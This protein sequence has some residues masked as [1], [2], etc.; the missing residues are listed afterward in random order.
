[1]TY[2]LNPGRLESWTLATGAHRG[3]RVV[4]P[5]QPPPPLLGAH[6]IKASNHVHEVLG[7]V[8]AVLTHRGAR[9]VRVRRGVPALQL[10]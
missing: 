10:H 2:Y 6:L 7:D 8:C 1:M 3:R 9:G 4:V 5:Q